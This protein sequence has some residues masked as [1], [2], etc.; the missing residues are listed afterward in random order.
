MITTPGS[1]GISGKEQL[2]AKHH[3]EQS[4]D[5]SIERTIEKG[6]KKNGYGPSVRV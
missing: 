4:W 1:G 5:F 6:E 2:Y 3:L